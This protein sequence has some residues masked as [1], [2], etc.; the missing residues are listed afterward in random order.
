VKHT[1]LLKRKR[2][3]IAPAMV[4]ISASLN[5]VMRYCTHCKG[6]MTAQKGLRIYKVLT[7]LNMRHNTHFGRWQLVYMCSH[8]Y[9]LRYP[10]TS[11]LTDCVTNFTQ[12]SV[13]FNWSSFHCQAVSVTLRVGGCWLLKQECSPASSPA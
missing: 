3:F 6:N 9:K 4:N 12:S 11:Y 13:L 7:Y 5:V 10:V 2:V 1:R 8:V